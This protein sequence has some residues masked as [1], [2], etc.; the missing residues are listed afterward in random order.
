MMI[1]GSGS[2]L[3]LMDPDPGGPKHTDPVDS[4]PQPCF[5][6]SKILEKNNFENF[7]LEHHEITR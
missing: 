4:D 6:M 1:E 3:V 5:S 2:A 7:F